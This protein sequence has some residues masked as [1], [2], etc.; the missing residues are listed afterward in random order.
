MESGGKAP[1][2]LK[3]A[4]AAWSANHMP[5]PRDRWSPRRRIPFSTQA[6]WRIA[7]RGGNRFRRGHHMESPSTKTPDLR[8]ELVA[9]VR[10]EICEGSYDSP[11]KLEAA[12]ERMISQIVGH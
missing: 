1:N 7:P 5:R 11:E 4:C 8:I 2:N 10:R 9:R 12:L 3:T 6:G